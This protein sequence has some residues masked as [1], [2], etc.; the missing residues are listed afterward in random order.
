MSKN[1]KKIIYKITKIIPFIWATF[2]ILLGSLLLWV[3]ITTPHKYH[4]LSIIHLWY[5][6][7]VTVV[8]RIMGVVTFLVA[9]VYILNYL[10]TEKKIYFKDKKCFLFL[11]LFLAWA[12]ICTLASGIPSSEWYGTSYRNEGLFSYMVYASIFVCSREIIKQG[13]LK[14]FVCFF[15]LIGNFTAILIIL[16]YFK[17]PWIVEYF[18]YLKCGTFYQINHTG[19]Y[20]T[21]TIISLLGLYIY[22]TNTKEQVIYLMSFTIQFFSLVVNDTFGCYLAVWFG[23]IAVYVIYHFIGKPFQKKNLF[24]IVI[25]LILSIIL[26]DTVLLNIS[27]LFTDVDNIVEKNDNMMSAGTGRMTLWLDTIDKIKHSPIFGYGPEGLYFKFGDTIMTDRPHNEYLQYAAFFG[28]PGLILYISSLFCLAKKRLLKLKELDTTTII[29]IGVIIAYLFS[30]LF[31]N[32]MFYTSPFFFT[33]FGIV[34]FN[35]NIKSYE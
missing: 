22:T 34:A 5:E 10:H 12:I 30:A 13:S 27:T 23:T 21:M 3:D 26:S 16:Q 28:I 32:T 19:Y 9:S 11:L 25:M 2:P 8:F 7:I 20:L 4:I 17:I 6:P 15:S 1:N 33:F 31:G 14:R 29:A 24:P 18:P 35:N